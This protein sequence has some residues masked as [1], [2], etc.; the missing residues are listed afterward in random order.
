ML[1]DLNHA[2]RSLLKTPG[3]T[4]VAVLTLAL[5]I[6]ANSGVFS[7]LNAILVKPL[8]LPNVEELVYV[9][10]YSKQVPNMSVSY[11]NFLDWRDRQK[12]FAHFGTFRTQ[13]FNYIGTS[14][15]QRVVGAQFSADVWPA[16]GVTPKL[17]RWFTADEDKP[18]AART[19]LISERF[20]QNTLGGSPDILDQK[21]TLSGEIYTII[22]VMPAHFQMP[23]GRPDVWI[24][25]G[26]F[27][28]QNMER[29]NHPGLYCI[30]RLSPGVTF[31]S[32]RTDLTAIAKQLETEYP[33]SN[34]GTSI[35]MMTLVDRA[36]GQ[37]RSA[38][39]VSFAAACCVFL[40][41]CANVANLLL[42]RAAVRGR[43]FAVRAAIGASRWRLVRL[44]LAESFL[45]GLA[46]TGIGL[47]VGDA[48]MK[49]I[50]TLIPANSA[51]GH[52]VEMDM[53]VFLFSVLGGVGITLLFGL[54]PAITSSKVNLNEALAAGT[55]SGG[56]HVNARWRSVLVSGE[57]ALT[58]ILLFASG[59]M[60]RT[61]FNLYRADTGLKTDHVLS[62]SYSM[63]GRDWADASKRTQLLDRALEKLSALPGVSHVALTNPLPL[64]GNGNQTFFTPE[65]QPEP[66]PGQG[67]STE[68]NA[69]SGRYFDTMRIP[70]LRGTAFTDREKADDPRVCIIDAK[71]AETHFVGQDPIGKRIAMG[72]PNQRVFSTII[73]VV[74]HVENYGIGED[75]RVQL[76]Y[77]YRQL[78]PGTVSFVLRTTLE[79]AALT[80]A[81][82]NTM[83]E[84]ESTL[85]IFSVRTM[86]EVFDGTVTNQRIMLTLLSVFA[87]LAL[88]LAAIG[89][90]GVLSYI[91]AQRTREVGIRMALGATSKNVSQLMIGQGLKLAAYGLGI[92]LVGCLA[93][94][95]VLKSVVYGVSPRDPLSL[96]AVTALLIAIGLIASWLPARRATRI[97]PTEA[98]RAE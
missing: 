82:R 79:P 68:N 31:E 13:S 27:A 59:L 64:S 18:G 50:K 88:F 29:G 54:V 5:G 48:T 66:A 71:F 87:A 10:E 12:S 7:F 47:L 81:I 3:F 38:V 14:E 94:A 45:L 44:V 26:L 21:L 96:V 2:L 77:S 57:F 72:P 84:L 8:P 97:S 91:V 58:L 63:P 51:F 22:G 30:G 69:A 35:S 92:G 86:D 1:A 19:L 15:T 11:P 62:F 70:M 23:Q 4:L 42:A 25:F 61:I 89:L 39:W 20:W 37:Q 6:G 93:L 43:E 16:L 98:L 36:V 52:Q 56:G 65:G 90:Y 46:G 28:A 53:N 74:G 60:I 24:P 73:G 32:A 83:R 41:A 17:G 80:T 76:Y 78:T 85:P 40:I 95:Q 9:G 67:F 55:R 75:S 34:T 49:G 33:Q